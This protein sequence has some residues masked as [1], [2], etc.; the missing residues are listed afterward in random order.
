M[1]LRLVLE[2][3]SRQLRLRC[4]CI[5]APAWC[6]KFAVMR[7]LLPCTMP[8]MNRMQLVGRLGLLQMLDVRV[9]GRCMRVGEVAVCVPVRL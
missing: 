5:N 2:S 8:G 9:K 7:E 3:L 4:R 1:V 6:P